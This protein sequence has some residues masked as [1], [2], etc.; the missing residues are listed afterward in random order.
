MLT[1]IGLGAGIGT[2]LSRSLGISPANSLAA[3]LI[4]L[5]LLQFSIYLLPQDL[6]LQLIIF[7]ILLWGI[8]ARFHH[9]W[10]SANLTLILV[11]SGG[12][13]AAL[14]TAIIYLY[15]ENLWPFVK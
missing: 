7:I 11:F 4:T 10:H 13:T 14:L 12:S 1:I 15:N 9:S 2:L 8:A 3:Y 6:W 5:F